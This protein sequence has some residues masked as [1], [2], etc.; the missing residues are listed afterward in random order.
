MKICTKCHNTKQ[1][2]EFAYKNKSKGYLS[3]V[4]R[5]C[6]AIAFKAHYTNNKSYYYKRNAENQR[7]L[8]Q[9]IAELKNRPCHDC[10]VK[11]PHY[12]MDFDHTNAKNHN[13]SE[14]VFQGFSEQNV[15]KEAEKCNVV[16]SNCHRRRTWKRMH[17][18]PESANGKPDSFEE[19][20]GG[21]NPSSGAKFA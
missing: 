8:Q 2:K 20:Y 21:S 11:Y 7:K 12:L 9:L 13:V 15:R 14:M 17:P 5:S 4:C 1:L 10:G 16:C 3:P 19:S 18:I 6:Q